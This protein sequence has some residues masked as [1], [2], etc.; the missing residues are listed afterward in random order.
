MTD[1]TSSVARR[2]TTTASL[3][4]TIGSIP[5][6]FA[7]VGWLNRIPHTPEAANQWSEPFT[8]LY[9]ALGVGIFAVAVSGFL[10]RVRSYRLAGWIALVVLFMALLGRAAAPIS[11][12]LALLY[13]VG[14]GYIF[15][16]PAAF[17]GASVLRL[18]IDAFA[19]KDNMDASGISSAL[20]GLGFMCCVHFCI[21]WQ[22]AHALRWA[23][24][25]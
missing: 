2:W 9:V 13:I 23:C 14:T 16:I 8:K 21:F 4:A 15:A 3:I 25:D 20:A 10:S 7:V 12:I 18:A 1:R 24:A 19:R 6:A 22:K 11:G 5:F 17:F